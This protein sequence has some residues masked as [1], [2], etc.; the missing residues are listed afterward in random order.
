MPEEGIEPTITNSSSGRTRIC[1]L[2]NN[3]QSLNFFRSAQT[4]LITASGEK[5]LKLT[6]LTTARRN[7]CFSFF[8]PDCE[9]Q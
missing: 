4:R 7:Y 6:F 8:P 3:S 5:T 1:K 9:E 2:A